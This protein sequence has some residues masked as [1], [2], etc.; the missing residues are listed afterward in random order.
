MNKIMI[1]LI[2]VSFLSLST[3]LAAAEEKKHDSGDGASDGV[4]HAVHW[5]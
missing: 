5:T 4:H 1:I 2:S 3:M